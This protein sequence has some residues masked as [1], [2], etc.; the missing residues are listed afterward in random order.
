[1]K[2]GVFNRTIKERHD[3]IPVLYTEVYAVLNGI[4]IAKEYA[5][6]G[7]SGKELIEPLE[8]YVMDLN[9]Y[10]EKDI[11]MCYDK[12]Y[13]IACYEDWEIENE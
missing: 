12:D 7:L 9:G 6:E 10:T 4:K 3:E 11:I 8:K 2:K 1:M 5:E 13:L